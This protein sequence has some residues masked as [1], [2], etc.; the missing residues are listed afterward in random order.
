MT[1]IVG[2]VEGNK[3]WMAGDSVASDGNIEVVR[4]DVKIFKKSGVIIGCTGSYRMMQILQYHLKVPSYK[5]SND[6]MKYMVTKFIP[7][8][9][10]EFL[11]HNYGDEEKGGTFLIGIK[12]RLFA[13]YNDF[14]VEEVESGINSVGCGSDFALGSLYSTV[15]FDLSPK[16]RLVLALEVSS[17]LSPGVGG[18]FIIYHT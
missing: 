10:K 12:N 11:D 8:I 5:G 15:D 14:Q 6:L 18:P 2:L 16:E 4:K 3:V 7:A 13:I 9:K 1:C 17:E